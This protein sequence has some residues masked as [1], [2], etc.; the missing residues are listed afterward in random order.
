MDLIT[1]QGLTLTPDGRHLKDTKETLFKGGEG[2]QWTGIKDYTPKASSGR[3]V[4]ISRIKYPGLSGFRFW[5]RHWAGRVSP[6][7]HHS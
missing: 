2:Y 6:A 4:L 7:L 1:L 3:P 5:G